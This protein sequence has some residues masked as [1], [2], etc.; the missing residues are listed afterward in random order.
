MRTSVSA[1]RLSPA[2]AIS[3]DSLARS[4][5]EGNADAPELAWRKLR[6]LVERTLVRL[7]GTGADVSDLTQEV[8][9]RF[10]EKVRGLRNPATLRAFATSIAFRRAREE[11][12]RRRVRRTHESKVRLLYGSPLSV[13][14][15]PA[16]SQLLAHL[17]GLVYGLGEI[18]S[19]VYV[20]RAIQGCTIGAIGQLVD[21][22]P[23][24]V[25]RIFRR[26]EAR[27][28]QR[29]RH[30]PVL[31]TYVADACVNPAPRERAGLVGRCVG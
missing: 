15:N 20:L 22:S 4:L 2:W 16:E 29:L 23:S 28:A 6:P 7:L 14:W 17:A 19:R 24:T 1:R 27:L 18:E 9:A 13:E 12:K 25:R 11:I 26:A 21:Y 3:D 30:D 8:F 31:S 5:I 10:F